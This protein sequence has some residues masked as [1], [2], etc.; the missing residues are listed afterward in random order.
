MQFK[1]RTKEEW[2][3]YTKAGILRIAQEIY[4]Y[5]ALQEE[6]AT[7]VSYQV[8]EDIIGTINMEDFHRWG[9]PKPSGVEREVFNQVFNNTYNIRKDKS[10]DWEKTKS[11]WRALFPA[12]KQFEES[13][14]NF[15]ALQSK[16]A[17]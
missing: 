7:S 17:M 6:C 1:K 12:N 16:G 15:V 5:Y 3:A 14:A 13:V 10:V 9:P 4:S 2:H 11:E 8:G